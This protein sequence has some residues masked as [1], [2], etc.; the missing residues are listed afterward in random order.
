MLLPLYCVHLSRV[1]P[2]F[3]P[4]ENNISPVGVEELS[5]LPSLTS[6]GIPSCVEIRNNT[7]SMNIVSDSTVGVEYTRVRIVVDVYGF[8]SQ[9]ATSHLV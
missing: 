6:L 8:I 2:S 7:S 3:V 4:T 5:F 1:C 9:C